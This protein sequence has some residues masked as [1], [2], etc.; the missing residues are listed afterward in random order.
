MKQWPRSAPSHPSSKRGQGLIEYALILSLV[1]LAAIVFVNLFG[2][3]LQDTFQEIVGDGQYAPP[4]IGPIGGNFTQ[5][6]PTITPLPTET[7]TPSPTNTLLPGQN[8]PTPPPSSTP[9]QTPSPTPTTTLTP[10]PIPCPYGPYT[11]PGRVEIENFDCGGQG[12][13]YNDT[14]SS[15]NG[16]QYRP[17]EGVDIEST[18]GGGYNIGFTQAGEWMRYK[19]NITQTGV[20]RFD[21][22]FASTDASGQYRLFIDGNEISAGL[23]SLTN[24]GG[25]QTWQTHS[26]YP[27]ALVAGART[28]E[29][30][31]VRRT[32]NLNYFDLTLVAN[33]PTPSPTPT[34]TPTS[35][36]SPTPTHTPTPSITPSPTVNPN[37][38]LF[39]VGNPASLNASDTAIRNRLQGQGYT[40]TV[41]DDSASTTADA[42]GKALV[43]ISSTVSS[44]NVNTKFKSVTTPVML[45]KNSLYD[46]MEMAYTIGTQNNQTQLLMTAAN[47]SHPLAAGRTGTITVSSSTQYNRGEANSN[48]IIIASRTSD[49]ARHMIFAYT[50][51]ATMYSGFTAP[52]RRVGFFFGDDTAAGANANGWALFDAAVNWARTGN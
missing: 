10:S 7:P 42:T 39:V 24:T 26:V 43:I 33:T 8:S 44:N 23:Q 29:F 13:A 48:A 12:V 52:A 45:W 27:V 20:Y 19:V 46:D 30:R 1:A 18:S 16:G 47:S 11:I 17:S 49:T 50:Q 41:V 31:V 14:D 2:E 37:H 51:G 35:T 38:I 5:R 36:P 28:I 25:W 3:T 6:P 32:M 40:V 4:D 34:R 22:R 9:T 21:L 15:N